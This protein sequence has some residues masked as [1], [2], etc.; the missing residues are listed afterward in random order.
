MSGVEGKPNFRNLV[1]NLLRE[2]PLFQTTQPRATLLAEH[3]A[4]EKKVMEEERIAV[5]TAIENNDLSG[6]IDTRFGSRPSDGVMDAVHYLTTIYDEL[7][8]DEPD[9]NFVAQAV[10]QLKEYL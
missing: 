7:K 1:E 5:L 10:E 3:T 6:F 8:K 2:S 4:E 9:Q